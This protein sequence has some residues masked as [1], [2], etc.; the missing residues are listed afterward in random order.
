[1]WRGSAAVGGLGADPF[2]WIVSLLLL[3]SPLP[4]LFIW[5]FCTC[6][7]VLNYLTLASPP[8]CLSV[9]SIRIHPY[10]QLPTHWKPSEMH[11]RCAAYSCRYGWRRLA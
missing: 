8:V 5:S 4:F 10:L 9:L 7:I 1:M 6:C 2:A 3:L 11:S